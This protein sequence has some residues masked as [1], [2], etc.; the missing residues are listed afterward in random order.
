MM[1][2]AA[3]Q[4]VAECLTSTELDLGQ[5]YSNRRYSKTSCH[6][7]AGIALVTFERELSD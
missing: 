3:E 5:I 2:V 6:V 4:A 7:G 1:F